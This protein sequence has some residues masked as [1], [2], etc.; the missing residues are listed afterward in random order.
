MWIS[1]LASGA[2]SKVSAVW[3]AWRAA[4]SE[5]R[6]Q[7]LLEGLVEVEATVQ[8]EGMQAVAAETARE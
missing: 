5:G 3:S 7:A 6:T 4:T 1:L 2:F 8:V